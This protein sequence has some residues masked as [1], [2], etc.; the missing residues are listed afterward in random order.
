M[1][2]LLTGIV[3][4]NADGLGQGRVKVRVFGVHE[5]DKAILPTS[6]LPWAQVMLPTNAAA[7]T[8]DAG[9]ATVAL[10][11]DSWVVGF[12]RDGS[13]QQDFVVIGTYN[14]GVNGAGL[15]GG[16]LGMGHSMY[17]A[18]Q[19]GGATMS[20]ENAPLGE[21]EKKAIQ[22]NYSAAGQA[23]IRIAL[24][25]QGVTEIGNSNKSAGGHIRKYWSETDAGMGANGSQYCAAFVSW[26]VAESG[27]IPHDACPN[28]GST[29][30]F[31]AW[32]RRSKYCK[33]VK[34]P[35][36]VTAGDLIIFTWSTGHNHAAIAITDSDA[37][38]KF[39][40]IEG[41]THVG[42]TNG[43]FQKTRRLSSVNTKM[44]LVKP[45]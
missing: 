8:A 16:T 35:R 17:V 25:E 39:K 36:S 4:S 3:E 9:A 18:N 24:G 6:E 44:T 11:T 15:G 33:T 30:A 13:D 14:G 41:N 31:L 7:Q 43:V 22:A 29:V 38:G 34:H 10:L 5:A 2:N 37:Q 19:T 28:T 21:Q 1:T 20:G 32:G 23:H 40:T 26:A 12:F 42:G 45:S 27:V